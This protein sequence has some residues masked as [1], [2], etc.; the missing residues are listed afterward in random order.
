MLLNVLRDSGLISPPRWLNDDSCQRM[1]I[2]GSTAYGV[3][4]DS[5]DLDIYGFCIPPSAIVFPHTTGVIKGFGEQGETFE[6]WSEH[7]IKTNKKEYDFTIFSIVKYF[8]LC[9]KNN[10]NIIDAL[11]V[12]DNCVLHST[13]VGNMVAA[14]R[15]SFLNKN[16]WHSYKGYAYSNFQRYKS[17]STRALEAQTFMDEHEIPLTRIEEILDHRAVFCNDI[18][19][20]FREIVFGLTPRDVKNLSTGMDTKGLYHV[21]RLINEVEQILIE[22]D[23]DLQRS[24]EQLRSIRQGEWSIERIQEYFDQKMIALEESY[25]KSTLPYSADEPE[26]KRLLLRCL[27]EHYGSLDALIKRDVSA[28][29]V[30]KDLRALLE[31]YD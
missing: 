3:S 29:V 14:S 18:E 1:V 11:F 10:P 19:I 5:S 30:L 6:S 21:V 2:M 13:K 15:R 16:A 22:G 17:I 24:K 8:D 23:L 20:K 26:I 31:K 7:H 25:A 28:E 4:T 12:P 9:L 27:E